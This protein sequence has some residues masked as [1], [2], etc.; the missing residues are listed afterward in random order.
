MELT[1]KAVKSE[2]HRY[3][4]FV[5]NTVS[6]ILTRTEYNLYC[7]GKRASRIL[8]KFNKGV[9]LKLFFFFIMNTLPEVI[10][11]SQQLICAEM[12][13]LVWVWV[14]YLTDQR[15]YSLSFFTMGNTCSNHLGI[16]PAKGPNAVGC[17]DFMMDHTA[18][19]E[20]EP[21]IYSI[22]SP[23]II[24]QVGKR[25]DTSEMRGEAHDLCKSRALSNIRSC[26]T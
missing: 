4:L 1:V 25:R 11:Q 12:W 2:Q 9:V 26:C 23:L 5:T 14:V 22:Y 6:N 16:P 10:D 20:V 21:V 19:V 8:I 13:M 15:R 3:V 18:Q 7:V 24:W 17:T